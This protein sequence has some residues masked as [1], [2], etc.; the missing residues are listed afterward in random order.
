MR[1]FALSVFASLAFGLFC[2]AAP[3][4]AG[5]STDVIARGVD[6][7]VEDNKCLESILTGV[8]TEMNPIKEQICEC[9]F[10]RAGLYHPLLSRRSFRPTQHRHGHPGSLASPP[11]RS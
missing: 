8:V 6:V 9:I 10:I 2:S 4:P 1:S 3:T 7:P 11:R 5:V